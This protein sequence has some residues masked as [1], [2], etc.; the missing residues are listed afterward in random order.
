MEEHGAASPGDAG[1][2]VVIDLDDEIVETIIPPQPVA[3]FIGRACERAV[4][5]AV[6]GVFAPGAIGANPPNR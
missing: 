4:I 3:W 6:G 2:S 5:S 1:P